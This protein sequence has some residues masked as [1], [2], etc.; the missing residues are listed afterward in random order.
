MFGQAKRFLDHF[1]IQND[2]Y[3]ISISRMLFATCLTGLQCTHW[4]QHLFV[5]LQLTVADATI[6][7]QR[8][9]GWWE[10]SRAKV[11]S[12]VLKLRPVN[13]I[14]APSRLSEVSRQSWKKSNKGS[15]FSSSCL[16]EL[17]E[18]ILWRRTLITAICLLYLISYLCCCLYHIRFLSI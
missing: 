4:C 7:Q 6:T 17:L 3:L 11:S 16:T 18:L 8:A 2:L 14:W 10:V 15:E 9:K 5:S 13:L 12:I 1:R